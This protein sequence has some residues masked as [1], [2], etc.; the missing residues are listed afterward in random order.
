MPSAQTSLHLHRLS[1]P[2]IVSLLVAPTCLA[3]TA[4]THSGTTA[5]PA[6]TKAKAASAVEPTGP[7]VVIDTSMGRL[8]CRLYSAQVPELS[9]N[10]VGLADGSTDWKDPS[11]GEV[12]HGKSFYG[13]FACRRFHLTQPLT[14]EGVASAQRRAR[15]RGKP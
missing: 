3:Q 13:V 11:T 15:A 7:T 14:A 8:T 12:Q 6:A 4:K 2:F 5:K 9:A 10:F 1:T